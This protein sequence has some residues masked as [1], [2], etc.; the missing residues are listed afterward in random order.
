MSREAR[1]GVSL[2]PLTTFKI[3][4]AARFFIPVR[5]VE[6]LEAAVAFAREHSLAVF[7]LGGGSNVLIRDEGF[8]GLVIKMEIEGIEMRE[9]NGSSLI[10]AGVGATWDSVVEYAIVR[11]LWGIENLSGIP[12]S[13][14]GAVVQNIGAYGAALS[15]TFAWAEVY[16]TRDRSLRTLT[17][18]ECAFGYRGSIFKSEEGRYVVVR[19]AF[20]LSTEPIPDLS[21][22]DLAARFAGLTPTLADIRA[23]VL[24]I[25]AGKFPDLAVLGTAGSFFKNAIVSKEQAEVLAAQYPGLPLFALPES[26]DIKVPIGWFLDYRHGVMDTRAVDIGGA[27]MYEK[28]FLVLVAERGTSS[29][30]VAE[31]ARRVQEEVKAKCG[32]AIEPEVKII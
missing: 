13:V 26:S 4:G 9:E 30:S 24:E 27:R 5:S 17:A 8:D 25:R 1:E 29:H 10:I 23:A 7:I 3:G 21:Y 11:G 14:G 15:Q 32:L 12:G 2:A 31:L 20:K 28:Q 18:H 19:A 6:E 16:D 22:K